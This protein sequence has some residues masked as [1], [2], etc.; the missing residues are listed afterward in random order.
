M[1]AG[2]SRQSQWA[3][4]LALAFGVA[5]ET[6]SGQPLTAAAQPSTIDGAAPVDVVLT[7]EGAASVLDR[8][9]HATVGGTRVDV[10][11]DGSSF[12]I[13]P[14]VLSA[15]TQV[16]RLLDASN[17]VVAETRVEYRAPVEDASSSSAAAAD[18]R[19]IVMTTSTWFYLLV[20]L[21]FAS[22][23]LPFSIA[24]VASV[25]RGGNGAA[26]GQPL[27]L[28]SGTVRAVLA[29]LLVAYLGFYVLSSVL[30]ATEFKPPEFMIGMIATV[31]GFYFG[32]RTDGVTRQQPEN[33][34]QPPAPGPAPTGRIAGDV[35]D[36]GGAA[37]GGATVTLS[38]NGNAVNMVQAD[39][40]GAFAF[41]AVDPD[42]FDLVAK[43]GNLQSSPASVAVVA[44]QTAQVQLRL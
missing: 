4:V 3:L 9:D 1:A 37:V 28:P 36:S 8:I 2:L 21:L 43:S 20:T 10:R 14:P 16:I 18:A 15:G 31:V 33:G 24:I 44:N 34:N 17:M 22:I 5:I 12:T 7:V 25:Y 26:P 42:T 39:A 32:T 6:A 19:R 41:E 30:S 38:K 35:I 27:G 23:V 11:R 40:K 29:F 13:T